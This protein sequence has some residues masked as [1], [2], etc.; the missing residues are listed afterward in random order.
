M[1]YKDSCI[2]F[3]C[4]TDELEQASRVAPLNLILGKASAIV[5]LKNPNECQP[6]DSNS[7]SELPFPSLST[8][9]EWLGNQTSS[10]AVPSF[11]EMNGELYRK[12]ATD[13]GN[14]NITAL[15]IQEIRESLSVIPC[16]RPFTLR[17]V[18]ILRT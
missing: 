4:E 1:I 15:R 17:A 8:M 16:S 13:P 5:N 6:K 2:D 3:S 11:L 14:P 12:H 10:P 9:I 7:Q 18:A